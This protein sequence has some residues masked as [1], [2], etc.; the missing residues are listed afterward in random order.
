MRVI[1]VLLIILVIGTLISV[2]ALKR[3]RAN[4]ASS[5]AMLQVDYQASLLNLHNELRSN[6]R[7][8]SLTLDQRLSDFAQRHAERMAELD[9]L[10]HSNLATGHLYTFENIARTGSDDPLPVFNKW[11]NSRGHRANII[12]R[13]ASLIG[14]GRAT[15]GNRR[16]WV[17]VLSSKK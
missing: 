12:S 10:V 9:S 16:Y 5:V 17:V 4:T 7:I 3:D 1:L 14:F 6:Y 15:K 8:S 11:K 2:V 13:E